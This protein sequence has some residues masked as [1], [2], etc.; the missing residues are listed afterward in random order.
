MQQLGNI[1]SDVERAFRAHEQGDADRFRNAFDRTLE[2]IDLT[3]QD[4]R[5]KKRLKELLRTREV[6]CDYFFGSNVYSIIP[7]LLQKDFLN[8]GVAARSGK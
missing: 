8:Y 1:G 5:R 7:A 4:P 6:L 2:L 3:V